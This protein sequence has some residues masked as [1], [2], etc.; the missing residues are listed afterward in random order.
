MPSDSKD[1]HEF[2]EN[3]LKLSETKNILKL[4]ETKGPAV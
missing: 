2:T 3:I 4:S 1:K